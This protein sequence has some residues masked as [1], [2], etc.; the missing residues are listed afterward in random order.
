MYSTTA[1]IYADEYI[2]IRP[3]TDTTL[4]LAVAHVLLEEE[5]NEP[6]LIDRD[7]LNR[8]TVGFDKDHMPEGANPEENFTDYVL[9]TYDGQPKTPEWA[10]K[11]CGV[12][13]EKIREFALELGRSKPATILFAWNSARVE[14]GTH[15]CQAQMTLGA[16]TG[17]MGIKGGSC[18]ISSQEPSMNGGP[19]LVKI[20]KDGWE[21]I[22]NPCKTKICTSEHW[23]AILNGEYTSGPGEK[24]PIDIRMIYHSHVSVI[25]QTNNSTKGID[26]HRKVDFVCTNHFVMTPEAQHADLVLPVTTPWEK[27]GEVLYGNREILI[28][29]EKVIDPLFEAKDDIEIAAELGRRL[30]LDVNQIEPSS[31]MQASFNLSLIHI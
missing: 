19:G 28:W 23:D 20:G 3:A 29:S 2:P 22:E 15:V 31:H 12:S 17:N 27:D 13:P 4:I 18:S 8:C 21:K 10:S 1:A 16:M 9:G 7:F 30:G 6:D 24:T 25:N 11:I 5:K 26:A 14:K